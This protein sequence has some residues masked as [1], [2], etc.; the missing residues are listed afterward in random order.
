MWDGWNGLYS[1]V[2]NKSACRINRVLLTGSLFFFFCLFFFFV[3]VLFV[4][5]DLKLSTDKIK[6]N[7]KIKKK[8]TQTFCHAL[9]IFYFS[10]RKYRK[11]QSTNGNLMV[12]SISKWKG[13]DD[14][15]EENYLFLYLK[16]F[17]WVLYFRHRGV[18]LK[19]K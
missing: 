14:F 13:Q 3:C 9:F 12:M 10:G 16:G 15:T 2:T 1:T 11:L 8:K 18:D 4:F 19:S 7:P 6:T 5:R 17:G